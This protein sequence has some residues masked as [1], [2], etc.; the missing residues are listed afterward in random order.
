MNKLYI[1]RGLP[2]SGKT[3]WARQFV[4]DRGFRA[5][6][7]NRDD[8]RQMAHNGDFSPEREFFTLRAATSMIA[9]ALMHGYDV[10]S[11]DTNTQN[12]ICKQ[13]MSVASVCNRP[14]EWILFETPIE[15]CI[16]RDRKRSGRAQ[17]GERVIRDMAANV[18][19]FTPEMLAH[20]ALV[21]GPNDD[22]R[23]LKE[24]WKF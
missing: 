15:M 19:P 12:Y 14:I 3:F 24:G 4:M 21:V 17:V 18:D 5:C 1:C 2:A 16:E 22:Y 8:L 20:P 11:D 9:Q 13:L 6:R 7:V 10:V 23:P